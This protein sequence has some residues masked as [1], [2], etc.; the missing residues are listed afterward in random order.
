MGV[1]LGATSYFIGTDKTVYPF[2]S[3]SA[4]VGSTYW[5]SG[6]DREDQKFKVSN[7]T[8]R[9]YYLT[10]WPRWI[11]HISVYPGYTV[12]HWTKRKNNQIIFHLDRPVNISR[13]VHPICLPL[14][15]GSFNQAEI[16]DWT[17]NK[18]FL[19][20]GWQKD[21]NFQV[22]QNLSIQNQTYCRSRWEKTST[23]SVYENRFCATVDQDNK[24][25]SCIWADVGAVRMVNGS[26]FFIGQTNDYLSSNGSGVCRPGAVYYFF[27]W[28]EP[29]LKWIRNNERCGSDRFTCDDGKCLPL[30]KL[31]NRG[32]DCRDGTDE[33]EVFCSRLYKC[34]E[35][36]FFCQAKSTCVPLADGVAHCEEERDEN[37]HPTHSR[38]S[39]LIMFFILVLFVVAATVLHFMHRRRQ[40]IVVVKRNEPSVEFRKRFSQIDTDHTNES[41][42]V[43]AKP[44][45]TDESLQCMDL[46]G[47]GSF[48]KVYKVYDPNDFVYP[49]IAVK[50]VDVRKTL[51]LSCASASS[52]TNAPSSSATASNSTRNTNLL[53]KLLNEILVQSKLQDRNVVRYINYWVEAEGRNPEKLNSIELHAYVLK[54]LEESYS[55]AWCNFYPSSNI[56]IKMELCHFTLKSFLAYAQIPSVVNGHAAVIFKDITTGLK[57]IHGEGFIHRDLKPGNIFCQKNPDGVCIWKIGDFGLTTELNRH[58]GGNTGQVGTER[59]RSPE[60][61]RGSRYTTKTDM[62]SLGVVFLELVK[63]GGEE[64]EMFRVVERLRLVRNSERSLYLKG[65]VQAKFSVWV[66]VIA[67][68][69]ELDQTKRLDCDELQVMLGNVNY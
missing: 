26:Y 38:L 44:W 52:S 7:T 6:L 16:F 27:L 50:C 68:L 43:I 36:E 55:L 20:T 23:K 59:Y 48:G 28:S 34:K 25:Q 14:K 40:K 33:N 10:W 46:L 37:S 24:A 3:Y 54:L 65:L 15:A 67:K 39:I 5:N 61:W 17:N 45:M 19:L 1:V 41:T 32:G 4:T 69:V 13:N 56:F 12:D 9:C 60:M 30:T 51:I 53:P 2:E 18:P 21:S 29:V 62:Y 57:H 22:Y 66:K 49:Y 31:C 47:E 64:Y 11:S 42:Q 58:A 35:G 8:D 63:R